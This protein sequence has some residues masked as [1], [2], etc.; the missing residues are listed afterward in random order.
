MSWRHM[1]VSAWCVS[2]VAIIFVYAASTGLR[3]LCFA[4]RSRSSS[5]MPTATQ[6]SPRPQKCFTSGAW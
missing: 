6:P 4:G 5:V 2:S 3:A 1:P